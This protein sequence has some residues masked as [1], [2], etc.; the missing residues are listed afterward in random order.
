[1]EKAL[2][3]EK[4]QSL[5]EW[6][7]ATF[8]IGEQVCLSFIAG[9]VLG[10][11]FIGAATAAESILHSLRKK[12]P[13]S[14]LEHAVSSFIHVAHAE[15]LSLPE[16]PGFE[17]LNQYDAA[18]IQY[19]DFWNDYFRQIDLENFTPL[20]PLRVKAMVML[21]SAGSEAYWHDPMQ[22][23]NTGD[24]ALAMLRDG[25][26]NG[27]KEFLVNLLRNDT[28]LNIAAALSGIQTT[29]R[30]SGRWA[31]DDVP[32]EQ[33]IRPDLSLFYGIAWLFTRA[34]VIGEV[35][36]DGVITGYAPVSQRSWHE[37]TG[38][39]NGNKAYA[40]RIDEL[41]SASRSE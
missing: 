22:I 20:E 26:V 3:E 36:E 12:E 9:A 33:R 6:Y 35:K 32:E 10:L 4:A 18:I 7:F 40:R 38:R 25:E 31:Y 41:I 34:V 14:T 30:R 15:G 16:I 19:T 23:A 13:E 37:A 27:H 11:S 21:E 24:Y 28:S 1:M 17:R 5:S 39:Y 2:R 8:T 29:P